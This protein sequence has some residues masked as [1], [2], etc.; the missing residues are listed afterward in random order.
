MSPEGFR[1]YNKKAGSNPALLTH[2]TENLQIVRSMR[3]RGF[4]PV[5]HTRSDYHVY[6]S[7]A[8]PHD[9]LSPVFSQSPVLVTRCPHRETEYI[10]ACVLGRA[11]RA[12]VEVNC[13]RSYLTAVSV[14]IASGFTDIDEGGK[15]AGSAPSSLL[16]MLPIW[17]S[18]TP[19][20]TMSA[21]RTQTFCCGLPFRRTL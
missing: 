11:V 20:L 1:R 10:P 18:N 7:L 6:A 2:Y 14:A 8:H 13:R 4:A 19:P 9:R 17:R 3:R 21:C 5:S 12:V 15:L 16:G